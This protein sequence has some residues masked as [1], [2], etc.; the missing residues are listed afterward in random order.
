MDVVTRLDAAS[1]HDTYGLLLS[2]WRDA[3]L[4]DKE[5]PEEYGPEYMAAVLDRIDEI[6]LE[7]GET[8]AAPR[9]RRRPN[10]LWDSPSPS[11]T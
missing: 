11:M 8:D 2:L 5:A 9:N 1:S 3:F 6:L 7:N 10:I 4:Q